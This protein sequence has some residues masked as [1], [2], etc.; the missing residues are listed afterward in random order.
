VRTIEYSQQRCRPRMS[1]EKVAEQT[2]WGTE[3]ARFL[4]SSE[5]LDSGISFYMSM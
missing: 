3:V 5:K 4:S 1:S 2:E